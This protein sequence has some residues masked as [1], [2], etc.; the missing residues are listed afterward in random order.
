MSSQENKTDL[1]RL[2]SENGMAIK[3]I[4]TQTLELALAAVKDDGYALKYVK[5]EFKT[6][7]VGLIAVKNDGIALQ[8]VPEHIKNAEICL[9]AV[10][11]DGMALEYVNDKTPAII[12]MSVKVDSNAK[13]F[14]PKQ[15]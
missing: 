14:I 4:E 8:F 6:T 10:T 3:H 9:A 2:V 7:E 15:D 5:D 1:M 12:A 13:Q 11:R